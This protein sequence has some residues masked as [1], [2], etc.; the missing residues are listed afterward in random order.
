MNLRRIRNWTKN[1]GRRGE[2][3][4]C[5]LLADKGCT[6]LTRNCRASGHSGE[7]DI[8][9]LDGES[10]VFVEVKTRYLAGMPGKNLRPA[11][12]RRIR[13]GAQA[14]LR[15]LEY[16][17][18]RYRFDLVEV[19]AGRWSIRSILHRKN[20]FGGKGGQALCRQAFS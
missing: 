6:I 7:I 19:I 16:P 14:Y 12:I 18:I 15:G 4:A 2:T 3:A 10:L 8:V 13:R 20:A 9:A 1:L 17:D 5:R 11:Q